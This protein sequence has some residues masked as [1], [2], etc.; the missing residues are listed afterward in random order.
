MRAGTRIGA[1]VV[2]TAALLVAGSGA[3]LAHECYNASA[4]AQGELA[5]GT[6]SA[7][8]F[9]A[10][11]TDLA[12][13]VS[14]PAVPTQQ[15]V[16]CFVAALAEAGVPDAFAI[17]EKV[18]GPNGVIGEGTPSFGSLGHASD[19]QGIDHFFDAWGEAIMAGA[20]TCGLPVSP[21]V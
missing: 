1:V 2:A 18:A 20:I 3:A 13:F 6:H 10:T 16:D 19:G 15:Q 5:K 14:E 17:G 8:W 4:S 11:T 9:Y 12:Y 21:P 7:A